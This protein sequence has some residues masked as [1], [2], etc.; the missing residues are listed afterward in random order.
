MSRTIGI[1]GVGL[2]GGAMARNLVAAGFKVLGFDNNK[3]IAEAARADH[4][5]M[6]DSAVEVATSTLELDD[7]LCFGAML[8]AAGHVPLD[9]PLSGTSAQAVEQ[10][11][12]ILA[13]GDGAEIK[14]LEPVFAAIG[15]KTF[16]LGELGNGTRMKFIANL[17]VA[18]HNVA[19]GEAMALAKRAGLDPQRVVDVISAGAGNSRIFE[20]RAPMMANDCYEPPTMRQST[21]QKDMAAITAF[22]AS[23]DFPAVLF[24]ATTPIYEAA[25][26]AGRGEEDTASVCAVIESMSA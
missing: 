6:A 10:D 25:I 22:T 9:C 18:I 21:W 20:L 15:R 26:R 23:L 19:S 4:I 2:M 14:R 16:D 3:A 7:K 17:L 24:N 12:V 13:S 5:D 8:T 1:I 11:L